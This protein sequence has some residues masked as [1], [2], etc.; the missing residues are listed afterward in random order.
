[1]RFAV[2][3]PLEVSVDRG[4]L[5]LGGRK[6]RL[7]LAML[8]LARGA[9]VSRDKLVDGLWGER[10]PPSAAESLD[11][12]VYRLR[13]L[14]G[15]DRLVRE[16]RGYRLR[17]EPG[18][19]DADEFER[20]VSCARAAAD[21]D[22][23]AAAVGQFGAALELWR[24][25]LSEELL[26][27]ADLGV[28]A[29]RLEELRLS[30]LESRIDALLALGAGADL[31][32]ELEQLLSENPHRERLLRGLMLALYR[33]GRQT[34]ALAVFRTARAQ[35]VEQLGLEPGPELH[36]LHRRILRHDPALQVARP[37]S[38]S[39]SPLPFSRR[40]RRARVTHAGLAVL[41]ASAAAIIL[42][43]IDVLGSASAGSRA[44]SLAG[45]NGIVSIGMTA[46]ELTTTLALNGAPA[47]VGAG[48]GSVWVADAGSDVVLQID[49]RSGGQLQQL[50]VGGDPASIAAGG[51]AVW[52]ASSV[53]ATVTR[54]DPATESITQRISLPGDNL[55]AI[56]YG[57][58]RLWVADAVEDE[59]FELSPQTGAL[60]RTV[61]LDLDPSALIAAAGAVWVAGYNTATVEKLDPATGRVLANVHVGDGAAALA[62][63]DGSLW[64]A[65]S[66]D[67]TVTRIDPATLA[68][69]ATIPVGSGPAALASDS[70]GLWVADQYSGNVA[71]I[72]P[73]RD[74]V[75]STV[76]VGGA[77]TTLAVTAGRIWA[78]VTAG[79]ARHR[80]G[81]MT[82]LAAGPI[83]DT[84]V[85]S[86]TTVDP[87]FYNVA[88][89]PEF[90]GLAYDALVTFQQSPGAAGLRLVPDLALA[91]P[92]DTHGGRVFAF[93]IRPGIRYS[94]GQPVRASDFRRGVE[95]LFRLGSLG[96]T[97]FDTVLGASA[98]RR[99]PASC[100][101]AHGIV[102]NDTAGT[103]VFHLVT[104]DP[105]FLF[106]LTEDA[107]G[108]PIPP[109]TPD[110]EPGT[111]TAPGTGPYEIAAVSDTEIR[112][113]RN[114]YFREW[115]HAAQPAGNPDTIIWRSVASNEAA[116]TAIEHGEGDW[117]SG[118][119][120]SS[121]YQQLA[122]QDPAIVHS[123]PQFAVDFAPLNTYRAPFDD[124]RVRQ[125]LNYAID[126]ATLVD[127]YG[128]PGIAA[129]ICQPIAPGLPGYRRYCP[130]TAHPD[131]SGRWTGPDLG[132][133]RRLIAASH[134]AGE[135]IDLWGSPTTGY[136]PAGVPEYF[137]KVLRE[138]GYRVRLHILP[139]PQITPAMWRSFQIS[140]DGDWVANYPDPA[141]YLP[142]FFACNGG[143]SNGYFCDP[144]VDREMDRAEL[145]S[146]TDPSAAQ[147][148]WQHVDRQLTDAAEWVPTVTYRDLEITSPRLGNYEFNPVWG[149]LPDQAWVR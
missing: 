134:T 106:N 128:G 50:D 125:A 85:R 6:Q 101:L 14:L 81:T 111:R 80:G 13:K 19:L 77:P 47:S 92:T 18:E 20:L 86:N 78:G 113:V 138:L 145:L 143:N 141:S 121:Q 115:S 122:V 15:H 79:D 34:E 75:I 96:T 114:P 116:V 110:R 46:A 98:C 56:A 2:L 142:L 71:L 123:N 140:T 108:A 93:R 146:L 105:D 37:R 73:H 49:P 147:K 72:D 107:Y 24:G 12:Y 29:Q 57:D 41:T 127:L 10:P 66:L 90:T 28:Q 52:V 61:P 136:I 120:P 149:F 65:N 64:V 4:P 33:S 5:P 117:F 133:A 112:F 21:A 23:L 27:G 11:T 130:Y 54:I 76:A 102:T 100:D 131:S 30:A 84:A 67:A 104:P 119:L 31:V 59:L 103:V 9:V 69:T 124:V 70:A 68:T 83:T 42:V 1:M 39:K 48:D 99:Y 43:A 40:A 132:R 36:D 129:P 87:A 17:V 35:L 109:G 95:R 148:T 7:L 60:T 139:F 53:A 38:R 135:R 118:Q 126:R 25:P 74:R 63:A 91:L 8:L 97:L 55:G 89:N 32:A 144:N 58:G 51:G 26:D 3:G 137:A 45:S 94:D 88:P 22:D 62:L 82:I 44:A 16:A